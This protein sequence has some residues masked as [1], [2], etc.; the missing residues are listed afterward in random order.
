MRK[1]RNEREME[2][3]MRFEI[4]KRKK[5]SIMVHFSNGHNSPKEEEAWPSDKKNN[6]E[7]TISV[8]IYSILL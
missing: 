3:S 5:V 8:F 2:V 7:S 1:R 6:K 4:L